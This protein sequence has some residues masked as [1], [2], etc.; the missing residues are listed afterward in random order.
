MK[1]F[2]GVFPRGGGGGEGRRGQTRR[3]CLQAA[4]LSRSDRAHCTL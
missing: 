2:G 3:S 4:F 1:S